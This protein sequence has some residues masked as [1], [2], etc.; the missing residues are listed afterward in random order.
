MASISAATLSAAS[1]SASVPSAD[2]A[3]VSVDT[4][5]SVDAAVLS[6]AAVVSVCLPPH[7]A[8]RDAVIA[9]THTNV[10]IFFMLFFLLK[11]KI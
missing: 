6:A 3:A 10:V 4:A 11:Y 9:A 5:A 1:L 8:K 7:P 2:S